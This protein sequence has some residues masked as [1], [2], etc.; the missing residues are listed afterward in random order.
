MRLAGTGVAPL[1]AE[2]WAVPVSPKAVSDSAIVAVHTD[3]IVSLGCG[4]R[5]PGDG[6]ALQVRLTKRREK[7]RR[8]CSRGRA[9]SPQSPEEP[10]PRG[11]P[12]AHRR[13]DGGAEHVRDL[14]QGQPA[15][16]TQLGDACLAT[17][18]SGELF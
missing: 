12:V 11:L 7:C 3:M 15:E 16:E 1:V 5:P 6:E 8:T 4:T 18:E 17:I 2:F 10:C 14:L 9:L 13:R